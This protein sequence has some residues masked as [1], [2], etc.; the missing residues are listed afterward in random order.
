MS[1]AAAVAAEPVIAALRRH[2]PLAVHLLRRLAGRLGLCLAATFL[3]FCL[4]SWSFDPLADLL[5]RQPRPPQ[6]VIDAQIVRLGLDL[7]VPV[8]FL[9]RLGGVVTGDLGTTVG[10]RPI[11]AELLT[12]A[13]TSLRLYLLGAGVAI[14]VGVTVGLRGALATRTGSAE[15]SL[16]WTLVVLAVPVF[17]L[18]TLLK[19][20]WLPVN[21]LAGWQILAFSGERTAG[22]ELT[23]VAALVDRARHLVLPTVC[24]ALP[25]IAF[26]SRYQRAV[27]LDVV[28][29]GYVRAARARGLSRR[30]AF[31][32]H[33][34]RSALVPML[35][36]FAFSFGIH[37]AG[38]V[39]TE[40]IFGWY[41][42]GDWILTA[43]HD[44][45][46]AVCAAVT[47]LL[48]VLVVGAGWASDIASAALDPRLRG[49]A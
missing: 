29:S 44:H 26:F 45:D 25:Q 3:T 19:I 6:Q 20:L 13:G 15:L 18:G 46:A 10:G 35:S 33:G 1:T 28:D 11:G 7:P 41:G 39:F 48:G 36:L 9:R 31:L 16:L 40:R 2:R 32:R 4:A 22:W 37:L 21:E 24:I 47:L 17:V 12:R 38:G 8:R 49:A 14:V 5:S 27:A 34:L 43:I 42:L 23:G 30:A